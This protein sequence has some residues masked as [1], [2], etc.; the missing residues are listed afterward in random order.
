MTASIDGEAD[1]RHWLVDY[2]VTNIGCTPDEVDPNLSLA[3]LGVSSRDAVV[4]SGELTELLGKTV[5][6]IDF[7]EHPTINS[8]AA[9]L[10]AP[11]PDSE[12]DTALNRPGRSSLEEPIAV[13]GMGCRFPGGITGPDA[14]WQFLCDRRSAIGKVPDERWEQ[15]DDGS[16]EVRALL[17]RTT[18]WGS[19]LPDIDAFDAEF[20]EISP[21]EADK[22]D[23][24][25]RL[26]LEVAWEA[27][28]H[29]GIAPS[30]LRRS[31]TGVFAG[32]CLSEYGAIA[33]TDL[34][35]VDG[36]SNTGGAMSIIANRLSYFLDLRGPSV[37]VDTACSSSLVAIHLAC[38]GL[39]TQDCNLAIAAGVNLLLSPAV[40]RGFDQVG[41][42]SPTGHCRAF[43]AAADGFVRGEGAGV[44]VLKRLT[45]AQRDGD[46]VLAVICGSAVNQD[47]RSNGLMAPNPAAQMAVLRAAYTNAGMQPN[48]VDFVEAHGTGTLLGDPI[49]ARALGTVL[50]RG[51]PE[52]APLLIG[53][54][55]TNLGHTE[56]AAGI[57]GFIKTVLAV[58]HGRIPPNQRFESPN[59]HIPFAD[60]RMKVVDTLTEW[61]ETGHPRR[62]GVSSFGFGGTN[63]HV[64]IEQGQELSPPSERDPDPAVSTLVVAG[65]T[66]QRV[67][68]TAGVLADWMEGPGAEVPLADVAHTV[69]HHRSRQAKFGTV[70]ARDRAQ[71]VAGLRA[72][73]AGQHAVGV[74][75]PQEGSPG[76]GTV[77]V[78][79]GR[80]WQWP[81]MGRRLLVDEPAFAEAIADLE[82]VFVEQAGFSLHDVL[83][84]G[85]ELVGI[86]AIQLGLIGTQ[87][88][89]TALWRSYG[90]Q[91]DAVIGHSMGEVAAAVVAG[92]LTP[93]EGLRVTATR[94]R[95]MAPLSGQGGMALLELDATETKALIAD[96]PHVTLGIYNSSRQTVIAGP[97]GQI[98]E[99]ITRVRA[100]DRFASRVNIEVAPHNPAMDALQPQMRSEL[101]DLSPRTPT[102]PVI[103]TTYEDVDTCAVFDAGHWATNMRNP[104]HFQQAIARAGGN[105]HTFIEISA[106]PLLTQAIMDT[107]RSAQHGTRYT[108]IGTL[109]RDSD[110]TITFRTNLNT[111]HTDHPPHTPHPPEPHPPIPTTPWQHHRHWITT[112]RSA[113]L[114]A[115]APAAGTLLGQ[116]LSV[117]SSPPSHLW[118]ARLA[119][120]AKP[121]QGRYRFHG[122]DLVPASVVLHTMVSAA[123]ELGYRTLT[124]IR[125]EQ[126][127]FADQPRLIQV[128][129]DN[130]SISLASIPAAEASSNRWTRHATARLSS[131]PAGSALPGDGYHRQN[132]HGDEIPDVAA[133]FAVHG[134]DGL[135]FAW[136]VDSWTPEATGLTV[137]IELPEA[138]PEGSTA[139]LLDAAVHVG[140]LADD[141]DPRLYVPAGIEQMWFGD[142]VGAP[143]AAV[144]LTRTA[145]DGDG[146]GDGITVDVDITAPGGAPSVSMRS[147]RYRALDFGDGQPAAESTDARN[148]VHT[149]D[150]QPRADVV[151][152]QVHPAPGRVTGPQP[153]AVIGDDGAPLRTHLENGGYPPAAVPDAHYLLYVAD[154][155]P[156]T[157]DETDVDFSVRVTAE[158]G[159][160]VKTL[161]ARDAGEPAALWIVTRGVHESVTPSALRQSFLWGLAGVIAAEHPELWG[162]LV[163]LASDADLDESAPILVDL[164]AAP[165]KSILVSRDGVV[166][167]PALAPVR[168]TPVRPSLQCRPD[169]AY[170]ITGG[171]GALG[172]L[173]ADWLADRGARR[174]VLTGRT[175]LP[176]RRDWELDT[177]DAGLR[178]K[179]DAIRALEMRGVTVEA[180]AVDVGCREDVQALLAR[181]DRDG[182][183]PVRGIIHAAGV[184]NDQ[185]VTQLTDDAV[186]QVMWP[187]VAGSQV[188]HQAFPP[189]SVDFFFLTASAA[190]IFGIPGQGSYAAANSYLDALARARRQQGCHTISLDWVAWR[191]LGFAA[192]AQIVSDELQRMGSRDITPSEAF[193]AW[194]YVD[195]YDVAQAVV[196]PVPS[197]AAAPGS[198]GAAVHLKP[199]Q[200]WSQMAAAEVRTEL[201]KGLRGII[202]AELRLRETELDTDR[203]F[204]ELGLNSLMAMAIRREAEQF[205]GIELS[206]TMLF[207]HP[208]VALLAQYLTKRVAPQH[209]SA[210]DE[211]AALS[212]SAG[213]VLDSLFDRIE[214]TSTEGDR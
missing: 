35:Q 69:N 64:V 21:S 85:T 147:L 27:L 176:P 124:D 178:T 214:S 22:M 81:G 49:E 78:Y 166:L 104:V 203:P 139:P 57:A 191:G 70:V 91:P 82:P 67:A 151:D 75:G 204:A 62:A 20:F 174:L 194:E 10:T 195:G 179:I 45:D 164:L 205:V 24:Q 153:V 108:S 106:H 152:T 201:E 180:V 184:T 51:R 52:D 156:A 32:S 4:L 160:L 73:A 26:L 107:L 134:V 210:A 43:D 189:G 116:H 46:R 117:L 136:S 39:R 128:V 1:L 142:P 41:A 44:V 77:F 120:D 111:V 158:I 113:H 196:V 17:D 102:I 79:S 187:K 100:R 101:A 12:S 105:H 90:V 207:N 167:A 144:R 15:F 110:D 8:L 140:A 68:A 97:T 190:G 94:S 34:S 74:V 198:I 141:T 23:P 30:A 59:P 155:R 48:E 159:A 193:T 25:Q 13:I 145:R 95:L 72:L 109:Q 123:T 182:A 171:M 202:A 132:V 148:F 80:G 213:S 115:A 133:L 125:F 89:L 121:Y 29:A 55:K 86:E 60:L 185:L 154:S 99:L 47:G 3:D 169:T 56:A 87:L 172:L 150:W 33:S 11:E 38:Q 114:A 19:F 84:N 50:G 200:D 14:L 16:P 188:L 163:D 149:I 36:W 71:A 61:P 138:L 161:A 143:R 131:S 9:Y 112:K 37:A 186:R 119:P 2:L 31:Q 96:Y 130:L 170:L 197:P 206:A 18:R 127:V 192:D 208:T 146:D 98:D 199:A 76:P 162:G 173:M 93:A 118:Q 6:P 137:G 129:A 211:I 181:R 66:A 42:L 83:A 126:P 7:W 103:S 28:E 183:A 53:A 135:P 54:V 5:S 40:F 165:S 65:K 212:A 175:P 157:A 92:A 177:L 58:Q 122:V 209:D 63:A 168:G 88:A